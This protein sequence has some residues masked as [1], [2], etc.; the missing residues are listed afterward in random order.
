M[1]IGWEGWLFYHPDVRSLTGYGPMKP[2]PF[3]VMK[4]PELALQPAAGECIRAFARELKERGIQLI[5][6]PV[7]LK[8]M[9]YP[10]MIA[11]NTR[12]DYI[13]HPDAAA[14]YDS[15]RRDGVDVLDLTADFAKL[16]NTRKHLH[17]LEANADNRAIARQSEEA[18]KLKKDAFLKQDTHWTTDAMR[19]TA[20]KVAD[21]VKTRYA[22]AMRPMARTIAAV[23]GTPRH[24][25]GDLVKLL[26]LKE[27]GV[28]FDEE[29]AFM[30]VIADGT[31]DRHAPIALLGDSFVNIFDDPTLGFADSD[32]PDERIRAGFAQHLSLTLNQPLDVIAMNGRGSTGV[33]REFA[34]RHDDHVREKKLLIWVIAARDVLLSRTAAKEA[35]IEWGLVEWNP[36]RSPDATQPVVSTAAKLVIEATLSEKSKNQDVNGTPYRDALHAAVYDVSRVVEGTLDAKQIT[37]IQWTFKDKVLQPTASFEVGKSYRLTLSRWDAKKELHLLNLQDDT[38]AFDAERWFVESAEAVK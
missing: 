31:E 33:R 12:H 25:M 10:E 19:L 21:L 9:I 1:L 27:P 15:L 26:D 22:S 35:N 8:P 5:F 24:S 4:D 30:R 32:K 13:T 38:T 37:G 2:E 3:S 6:V 7:P 29:E 20:E 36:N 34:K 28:L 23:D 18:L 17:Y 14:F 16:R 11:P